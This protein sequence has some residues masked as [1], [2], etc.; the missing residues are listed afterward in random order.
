MADRKVAYAASAAYTITLASLATSPTLVEGRE[1]GAVSNTTLN[2]LDYLIGGKITTGTTPTAGGL[3]EVWAYGSVNDTPTYPD[4][5]DGTDS[6]ETV[7]SRD[8]LIYGLSRIATIPVDATSDRTY[9]FGPISLA[10]TFG[11][12]VGGNVYIPKNHGI[13][14]V[15]SA[16]TNL[17]A[18]GSNHAIWHT[19]IFETV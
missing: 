3:I 16:G 17:H 1:S 7:T 4:M 14:V 13:F 15:H 9:W 8:I 5:M 6:A 2:Y 18:T 19:G 11:R 12:L 10:G